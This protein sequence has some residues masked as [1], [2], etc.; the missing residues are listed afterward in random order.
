MKNFEEETVTRVRK[1]VEFAHQA[2]RSLSDIPIPLR[3]DQ[4]KAFLTIALAAGCEEGFIDYRGY[5]KLLPDDMSSVLLTLGHY[6][7]PLSLILVGPKEVTRSLSPS[8]HTEKLETR[9]DIPL[10]GKRTTEIRFAFDGN[11]KSVRQIAV[12]QSG[13]SLPN[14]WSIAIDRDGGINMLSFSN[15]AELRNQHPAFSMVFIES[16]LEQLRGQMEGIN[17]YLA[18]E[19]PSVA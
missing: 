16:A 19:T 4:P 13:Y 14:V 8:V 5:K 2:S 15:L 18:P 1:I 11:I 7:K 3:P 10:D 12:G 9:V 17:V 6:K